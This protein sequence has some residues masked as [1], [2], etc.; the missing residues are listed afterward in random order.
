MSS[1]LIVASPAPLDSDADEYEYFQPFQ[2]EVNKTNWTAVD[3]RVIEEFQ[4]MMPP[5]AFCVLLHFIRLTTG[6]H[7]DRVQI[8]ISQLEDRTGFSRPTVIKAIEILTS[9]QL[10][11]LRVVYP[12]DRTTAATYGLN[13]DLR[14]KR[15]RHGRREEPAPVAAGSQDGSPQVVKE[16]D[17]TGKNGLPQ[18]VKEIDRSKERSKKE[19]INSGALVPAASGR[20][21][22]L[23]ELERQGYSP[24]PPTAAHRY[25]ARPFL[26][27][28]LPLSLRAMELSE[29]DLRRDAARPPEEV[30]PPGRYHMDERGAPRP[31]GEAARLWMLAMLGIVTGVQLRTGLDDSAAEPLWPLACDLTAEG[32]TPPQVWA[33]FGDGRGFWY[34]SA[35]HAWKGRRPSVAEV[36]AY[37]AVGREWKPTAAAGGRPVARTTPEAESAW[38]AVLE[39]VRRFNEYRNEELMATLDAVTR[40]AL[41]AFGGV[42]RIRSMDVARESAALKRQFIG[43]YQSAAARLRGEGGGPAAVREPRPVYAG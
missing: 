20:P 29:A 21:T 27:E 17:H 2:S 38:S 5:H 25:P 16:I 14:C 40:A 41:S 10:P 22:P 19:N 11:C 28:F 1:R 15:L 23:S 13:T 35:E 18:V 4:P 42:K 3:N 33:I 9:A 37:W 7:V 32:V 39:G 26:P 36:K 24:N 31:A 8:S 12:G 43:E 30:F 34:A 6:Y